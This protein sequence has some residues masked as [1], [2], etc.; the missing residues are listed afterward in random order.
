MR[1]FFSRLIIAIL[2][3][4]LFPVFAKA[5]EKA[6]SNTCMNNQRQITLAFSMYIQDHDETFPLAKEWAGEL[7]GN[8][9]IA[10]KVFDCPTVTHIGRSSAPDYFFVG[11]SFLSG[12]A[13]GEVR[14]PDQAP[15]I[16]DLAKAGSNKPYI[17]HAAGGDYFAELLSLVDTRH[18]NGAIIAYVDGH[19]E[20]LP[21]AR[22]S[23]NTFMFSAV[24]ELPF[25]GGATKFAEDTAPSWCHLASVVPDGYSYLGY[26]YSSAGG[27]TGMKDVNPPAGW[28]DASSLSWSPNVTKIGDG[29]YTNQKFT[30]LTVDAAWPIIPVAQI[31]N[32]AYPNG[33]NSTHYI[34]FTTT[35]SAPTTSAAVTMLFCHYENADGTGFINY[36]NPDTITTI[37]VITGGSTTSYTVNA[38][39]AV[40]T[41]WAA[42]ARTCQISATTVVLPITGSTTYR[43]NVK[44]SEYMF[45]IGCHAFRGFFIPTTL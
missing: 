41:G 22:I 37:D 38:P 1:G 34:Q 33:K 3:A 25:A 18:N 11:G 27:G 35:A 42:S 13:L 24:G 12:V 28:V 39:C 15:L 4:I 45:S 10:D 5:R 19:V 16:C 2:A 6:R 20:Y 29:F 40:K 31:E 26:R 32:A 23:A 21:K 7:G 44:G 9:G 17:V 36:G 8:Y 43:I 14:K 30:N